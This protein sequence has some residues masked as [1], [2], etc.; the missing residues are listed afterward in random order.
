MDL[1]GKNSINIPLLH[2]LH[3]LYARLETGRIMWL[4]IAGTRVST[5]VS[6]Q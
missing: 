6:A 1:K 2:F 3:F 4:G 5:Q